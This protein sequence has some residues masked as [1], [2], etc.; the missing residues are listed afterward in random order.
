MCVTSVARTLADLAGTS[1]FL[2]GV[3]AVDQA[4]RLNQCSVE[5]IRQAALELGRTRGRRARE[6]VLAF[7]TPLAESPGESLSRVRMEELG[8]PRPVLQQRWT[9]ADGTVAYTDF[10]WPEHGLI[11]EFD[12]VAKY[13]R[14]DYAG[15]R[16]AADLVMAEKRREDALRALGPRVV[17]WDWATALDRPAFFRLLSSVGL[18]SPVPRATLFEAA[19]ER[20]T[21][22]RSSA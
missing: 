19:L 16:T 2:V 10:W 11:G 5:D 7:A 3:A 18:P 15:H 17:R 6:K 20:G 22:S 13:V 1:S 21:R 4:L 8:F 12:G 9:L 14:H